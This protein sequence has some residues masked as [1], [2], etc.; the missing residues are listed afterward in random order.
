M[1]SSVRCGA[2]PEDGDSNNECLFGAWRSVIRC[3]APDGEVAPKPELGTFRGPCAV[4]VADVQGSTAYR[5]CTA[6]A[7]KHR[8]R[9]SLALQKPKQGLRFSDLCRDEFARKQFA[10]PGRVKEEPIKKRR[11]HL[12][13]V[14]A[15]SARLSSRL[16]PAEPTQG[17]R[18]PPLEIG[19]LRTRARA[20]FV[21]ICE[22]AF[23]ITA[24]LTSSQPRGGRKPV[25]SADRRRVG[26][27]GVRLIRP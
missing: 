4:E 16:P 14:K 6:A 10:R 2:R 13:H 26:L 27:K 11:L 7:V 22:Q 8:R 24:L 19:G 12:Q 17:S 21:G 9:L 23:E 15:L 1:E 20:R 25:S 3:Y 5:M 18:P